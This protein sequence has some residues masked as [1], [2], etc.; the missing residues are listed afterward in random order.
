MEDKF[1]RTGIQVSPYWFGTN[2]EHAR[3]DI[4]MGLSAQ[5][6]RNRKFAGKPCAASGHAVEWYPIGN[7][8][9][10]SF[11]APYTRHA[12]GHYHMIRKDECNSQ[13]IVNFY[14]G[15]IAGI[16]QH[17]LYIQKAITYDFAVVA[18]A[19][20]PVKVY[21]SLTSRLGENIYAS[22]TVLVA[23]G[24]WERY[25]V[26]LRSDVEDPDADLRITFSDI[27][28]LEIGAVSLM[29]TENFHGMRCDVIE[30]LKEMGI[31]MI[32]WPGGNFAG[33]YNWFDGLLPVDM[34]APLQAY[35]GLDTQPY[36]MGYD[37]HEINTDD[38][39]A[40]CR[41]IGAEPFITINPSWNTPEESAMWVEYCNGGP[42]TEY[43]KLRAERGYAEPY[44]VQFWSL[45]NEFG[46]GHMEGEN[47]PSGYER[48]VRLHGKRMR[49][50]CN[51]LILCSSGP[52]PDKEWAEQA[53]NPLSDLTQMVSLHHYSCEGVTLD[54]Y[55]SDIR[56]TGNYMDL[57]KIYKNTIHTVDEFRQKIYRLRGQLEDKLQISFDEWNTWYSWYR[58]S[59]VIEG[60]FTGLMFHMFFEEANRNHIPVVCHFEAVNE[61]AI[62]VT[63]Q[64]SRLTA[65]GQA[66]EMMKQHV[67][68]EICYLSEQLAVTVKE[69]I[70][71][72]T[73]INKEYDKTEEIEIPVTGKII[74][75]K[76]YH[77]KTLLPHSRFELADMDVQIGERKFSVL[78]P[79]HS[80]GLI[81]IKLD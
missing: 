66:F 47:T 42:N 81:R 24:E 74:D 43:G 41:E 14:Q 17:E 56:K 71:T 54:R 39:I 72:A 16:G 28:D 9:F 77:G 8:T 37:F 53:A 15:E 32:R 5:M 38:F 48:T 29:P 50:V 70:M 27:A 31:K 63:P 26:Q 67:N 73:V 65:T 68:G 58:P 2:L 59:C 34:R 35:L 64:D 61:G 40:L 23:E 21:I 46:Y 79:A 44:H 57:E 12:A 55:F 11:Y 80:M 75:T 36:T 60:I 33:E 20:R 10:F 13:K 76:L 1:K 19:D 69:N 30:L 52:Y 45:G 22:E 18:K 6:L 62:E 49:E 3:S 51:S 7:K 4:F 25:S 78:I